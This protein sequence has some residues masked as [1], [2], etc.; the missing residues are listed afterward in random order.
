MTE[1]DIIRMYERE[2]ES[3][4]QLSIFA[5]CAENTSSASLLTNPHYVLL[6]KRAALI[7]HWDALISKEESVVLRLHLIEGIS[8][9]EICSKYSAGDDDFISDH[10]RTLQRIQRRA[11]SKI[12]KFMDSSFGSSLDFLSQDK[13]I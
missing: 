1:K 12:A 4:I 3:R 5:E 6:K 2:K 11:V 13:T 7:Q 9:S 10:P 8:W